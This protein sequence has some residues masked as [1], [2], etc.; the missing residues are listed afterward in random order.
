MSTNIGENLNM[1][2]N[3]VVNADGGSRGNPGPAAYGAVV[4]EGD[5]VLA[6][7]S[8]KIGVAT[9]NVAEYRGLIAGLEAAHDIDPSA[10]IEVRLDSKLVVE[11]MS[12]KWKIR[13]PEM[14][15][16]ALQA[17]KIHAHELLKFV[18]VPRE[19]NSH[20]DRLVNEALDGVIAS[21]HEPIQLNYLTERL[22]STEVP[23]T[24]Y[25]VR[26]G[27][28]PLTPFR[29]FSG[30]GPLNPAL[31]EKGLMEADLVAKE[32]AKIQPDVLIASPLQRTRQTADRI[33]QAT[34]L[35]VAIDPIWTEC[36][37]GV[38]DGMS[39]DEVREAYP[40]EYAKWLSTTSY[41]PPEGESYE[42]AMARSVQGLLSLVDDYPGKKVCVVTHNGI[43]KTALAA[44]MKVD[45]TTIFN[46]DVSPCSISSIS[47]WPSDLLMA[48]RSTNERGHLR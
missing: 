23:T 38:W 8:G 48:V 26:H 34:G 9:N 39:I 11:Q 16:L 44:A 27:E 36:S 7:V 22:I 19:S 5:K 31:T 12:G 2:R 1:A 46:I 41:A 35:S 17:K 10:H 21:A 40:V 30:D 15:E 33:A 47:M 13:H 3:L 18:W 14:R 29:K 24:V 43:I 20:A 25:L 37:F 6:E 4:F 28:T 42:S 45:S 32:I